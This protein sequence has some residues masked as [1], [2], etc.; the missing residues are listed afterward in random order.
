MIQRWFIRAVLAVTLSVVL[1]LPGYAQPAWVS[2]GPQWQGDLAWLGLSRD[3]LRDGVM[4]SNM[5]G[6][7]VRT[8]DHGETWQRVAIPPE[9]G[10][11]DLDLWMLDGPSG[12]VLFAGRVV[13]LRGTEPGY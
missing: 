12:R 1:A 9:G 7:L 10:N 13:A 4:F 8:R 11:T 6:E 3:W 2:I 5:S